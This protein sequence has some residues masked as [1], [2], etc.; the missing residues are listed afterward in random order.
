[1]R[2]YWHLD[3]WDRL[4]GRAFATQ[5]ERGLDL[6]E[7]S[8]GSGPTVFIGPP[9]FQPEV[10][11]NSS[12]A[13]SACRIG[14]FVPRL[15]RDEDST[16]IAFPSPQSI[17]EFVRRA[18]VGGAR[19]GG[20]TEGGPTVPE[21]NPDRSGEMPRLEGENFLANYPRY[22]E[23]ALKSLGSPTFE[24]D[25]TDRPDAYRIEY[26]TSPSFPKRKHAVSAGGATL[27]TTMLG[28]HSSYRKLNQLGLWRHAAQNLCR[29]IT[30][31]DLLVD[32]TAADNGVKTPNSVFRLLHHAVSQ[33]VK[34][35]PPIDD[36]MFLR[37]LIPLLLSH[38][39]DEIEM[40]YLRR[41]WRYEF[42]VWSL[43]SPS[44]CSDRLADRYDALYTWPL[45]S[46]IADQPKRVLSVG[47]LLAQF[48]ASP[49]S[50][51][52]LRSEA[53]DILEFAAALL[54]S[55]ITDRT[56]PNWRES[57]AQVWFERSRPQWAFSKDAENYLLGG[58][59]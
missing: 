59:T 32:W 17:A 37:K 26:P 39:L 55:R 4:G 50:P 20:D 58:V 22:Y 7:V 14:G 34:V 42:I 41:S 43:H 56:K 19:G 23:K 11:A 15:P 57:A 16:E 8:D 52:G 18:F 47:D 31:L 9:G 46:Q 2:N 13:L 25:G 12:I 21:P 27:V 33:V 35:S 29:A 45:P 54:A 30:E 28:A 38:S 1:M 51:S 24:E 36:K 40:S 48:L 3:G 6:S 49:I 5:R 10:L 44:I 53:F